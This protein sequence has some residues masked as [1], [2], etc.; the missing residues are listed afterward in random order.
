MVFTQ[1]MAIT[2]CVFVHTTPQT[3][4]SH[5]DFFSTF[6]ATAP[7]TSSAA[8]A[9]AAVVD[10]A[11]D[12][13]AT[14][15]G[16][17]GILGNEDAAVVASAAGM[18]RLS[19]V[20]RMT[21]D[22]FMAAAAADD[23]DDEDDDGSRGCIPSF[24]PPLE[25]PFNKRSP[26][27]VH[28]GVSKEGRKRLGLTTRNKFYSMQ[29]L[30]NWASPTVA[31]RKFGFDTVAPF[32]TDGALHD[33]IYYFL[34]CWPRETSQHHWADLGVVCDIGITENIYPLSTHAASK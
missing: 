26:L 24:V 1:D 32:H 16:T 19:D 7:R 28:V 23:D 12:T 11:T 4:S 18:P 22:E 9:A 8:A 13:F 10:A 34:C 33:C 17:A 30:A 14:V 29:S 2:E 27:N 15:P 6:V 5:D 21:V 25:P 31:L 20:F 3:F